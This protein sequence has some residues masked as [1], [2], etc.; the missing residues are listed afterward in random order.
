MTPLLTSAHT[1]L[2]LDVR[3]LLNHAGA[4]GDRGQVQVGRIVQANA[5]RTEQT[6]NHIDKSELLVHYITSPQRGEGCMLMTL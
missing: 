4:A 3:G 1:P 2:H 5:G 6:V